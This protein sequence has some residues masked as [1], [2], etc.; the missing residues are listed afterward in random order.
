MWTQNRRT[1]L[2]RSAL[3]LVVM[4]FLVIGF[5]TFSQSG[6]PA[7]PPGTP[8]PI[9]RP[10]LELPQPTA[11]PPTAIPTDIPTEAPTEQPPATALPQP[12]QDNS[13]APG[14][15]VAT[16]TVEPTQ[17][18][19]PKPDT[20]ERPLDLETFC[21]MNITN[22]NDTNPYTFRFTAD[23]SIDIASY[24]WD[25]GDGTTGTGASPA[26]KTYSTV[27]TFNITLVC[28]ISS[29]GSLTLN[30]VINVAAAVF[31][32]FYF[33]D[34]DEYTGVPPFNVPATNTSSGVNLTYA[35]RVSGS[36]NPLDAGLYNYTTANISPT[37]TGADFVAAGFPASGPA[38][39]WYHLTVTDPASGLSATASR[40]VSFTPEAPLYTFDLAPSEVEEGETVTFTAVDLGGGPV[41]TDPST[42]FVW[43]FPGGSP[44]SATGPGPHVITY[45]SEG[46]YSATLN[47]MGPGGG[48]SVSKS[49][50]VFGENTPVDAG[51]VFVSSSGSIG[52][53]E[54][55]FEN[56]STG[57]FVRST[58]N[59]I[60]APLNPP[61]PFENN[62][63]IVCVTY[64]NPGQITV[65]LEVV[66]QEYVDNNG[67]IGQS[68][69]TT[70]VIEL[71]IAPIA[72]FTF[73][74]S[75]VV[76]QG[77]N[78]NFTDTSHLTGGGPVSS[79]AW[80][81]DGV[82]F[83]SQSTAQ[84]PSG[85]PFMTVGD[86]IVRLTVTGPGGSSY[87]EKIVTV[88]RLE[89]GCTI[90]GNPNNGVV[91]PSNGPQT[92]TANV[93]NALG[94]SLTYAW[95]LIRG[96]DGTVLLTGSGNTLTVP[97]DDFDDNYGQYQLS[98]IVSTADGSICNTTRTF[99]REWRE[100]DCRFAG[101]V[102][103]P[104]PLYPTGGTILFTADVRN[105]GNRTPSQYR[106]YV[107]GVLVQSGP[108]NAFTY[109]IPNDST[110]AATLAQ[111]VRYEVDV[112]NTNG[113]Q[114]AYV[115]ATSTCQE[116]RDFD[117]VPWPDLV[118]TANSISGDFTPIPLNDNDG[119]P[120]T[121]T[122]TVNVTGAAGRPVTYTW[123]VVGGTIT[124]GQGSATV[125][126]QWDA[127]VAVEN[128][129]VQNGEI[130][131]TATVTN[132]DGISNANDTCTA[133]RTVGGG[134]GVEIWY[135]SLD[136][137]TPTGDQ[138]VVIGEMSN[139]FTDIVHLYGRPTIS[140]TWI[141]E[142]ESSF[143]AGDWAVVSDSDTTNPFDIYQFMTPNGSYRLSYVFEVGAANGF[144]G[145]SCTSPYLAIRNYDVGFNF[146]C[147]SPAPL[148]IGNGTPN[149]PVVYTYNTVVD[150]TTGL[151]LSYQWSI[152][153]RHGL[154]TLLYGY[155]STV[156]G[157]VY[158]TDTGTAVGTGLTLEQLGPIGPGTYTLRLHVTD[159]SGTATNECDLQRTLIV[160][161]VDANYTYTISGPGT[162][163]NTAL[164][165]NRNIC[166]TNTSTHA[167][168]APAAPSP[169]AVQYTWTIGGPAANN[170]LG[171]GSFNTEGMPCFS[172]NA[173]GS[174]AITV[175]IR[176]AEGNLTD[177][178]SL[179]FNVYG[180]Q[181]ISINRIGSDTSS[182]QSFTSTGVNITGPYNWVFDRLT[183][184]SNPAF[185]TRNNVQNPSNVTGFT[186][187]TYRATVTGTGPLGNTSA[188][189]EFEILALNGLT[190]RFSPSQWAGIA[191]MTV[192]YTDRSISGSPITLWEWDLDGNGSYET[193]GQGPHCYTY[194]DPGMV[195]QVGLR[196]NNGSFTRTATN[197]IR[198]YTPLEASQNFSIVPQG[199]MA[200]C[201]YPD[202]V[203]STLV[204]W[205]FGDGN[206]TGPDDPA[207]HTYSSSGTYLVEMCFASQ[208]TTPPTPGCIYRPVSVTGNTPTP[209]ALT[210]S[211][212]CTTA[213]TAT[214]NLTNTGGAMTTPDQVR[215]LTESG[216]VV[217]LSPLQLAA[218]ESASFSIS[219]YYGVLTLETTDL[220]FTATTLCV[221]YTFTSACAANSL[222]VFTIT[223]NPASAPTATQSYTI[224]DSTGNVIASGNWSIGVGVSSTQVAV[225][226]GN[227]PYETYTIT[228]NGAFGN[229]TDTRGPCAP[230]PELQVT[231]VCRT[232][233]VSGEAEVVFT[234]TNTG[235]AMIVPQSYTIT[236]GTTP[237]GSIQLGAGATTEIVVAPAD[238]P[239]AT[240]TFTSNGFADDVTV[241]HNCG[242]PE[243]SVTGACRTNSTTFEA[244]VVFTITNT[245]SAMLEPQSYSI[246]GGTTPVN[247]TIQL[248]AGGSTEA[249]VNVND[250]P[251]A[252]YTFTSNGFADNVTVNH[253]CSAP[254][255]SAV[256]IC[257]T[258]AVSGEAEVGYTVT[259]NGA[260]MLEPQAYTVVNS[261]SSTVA[262][263]NLFLAN[264]ESVEI[265]IPAA[266]DPYDDYT[267]ITN[268]FAGTISQPHN[269]ARPV[270]TAVGVCSVPRTFNVTN[271]G[272][273]MLEAQAYQVVR[274][275]V[276][277]V[278]GTLDLGAGASTTV[279]LP[280][281]SDPYGVYRFVTAGFATD[282]TVDHDC[283]YP[284]FSSVNVCSYALV[285][286]VTNTGGTPLQSEPW[287]VTDSDGIVVAS[288][289]HDWA[290][291]P[292]LEITLTGLDPYRVYTF[293]TT[294][295]TDDYDADNFVR[296]ESP[297]L[298]VQYT[299]AATPSFTITNNGGDMLTP[300]QLVVSAGGMVLI[301]EPIQLAAGTVQGY[302]LDGANP[303]ET[304]SLST[305]G[306]FAEEIDIPMSCG[307]PDLTV[308]AV[309]GRP[310]GFTVT[311]NGSG[312]VT[313]H[314]YRILS[315]S[316]QSVLLSG[317][318]SL[319]AGE[320]TAIVLP[321]SIDA[322]NGVIFVTDDF[323]VTTETMLTCSSE[324]RTRGEFTGL[325]A[326][327]ATGISAPGCSRG[328][329]VF[330]VY[331]TDEVGGW[332]IFR[333]DSS[334]ETTR[335]SQRTNLSLGLAE[336]IR[337]M[338]PSLS[339]D[340]QW[341]VFSSDRDGNWEIYVAPTSGGSP[342][343]VERV[344]YNTVAIDSDPVWGPGNYIIY[345]T[346]RHGNW[347]LYAV[348]MNTG[349][350]FRLTDSE[351]NDINPYWSEDGSTVVFQSDR[352]DASG[353]RK[354]QVYEL[355]LDT[356]ATTKLSDGST[357]DVDP[358]YSHNGSKVAFRSYGALG[359][360]SRLSLMN[361]DGSGRVAFSDPAGDATNASWS[362]N[363]TYIAYQSDVD[364]DLDIYVY[365]VATGETRHLTDNTVA[366][367][368]PTW[369]CDETRV[370]WT[371]DVMGDANIFE[372][373]A[374]PISDGPI[375]VDPDADQLTFETS[376][377][378]Y[379]LS[380][381]AEENA[382]REGK[383]VRG[384]FGTQTVFLE[385]LVSLTPIDLSTTSITRTEWQPI[386]VCPANTLAGG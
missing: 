145:D 171:Q 293:T 385:P 186:P 354:W 355:D 188:S 57:N 341:I 252:T 198:T 207:C 241:N 230:Q 11:V 15:V 324:T 36:S 9:E 353:A 35:W 65:E 77:S 130:S 315:S 73:S 371:S 248:A 314:N 83:P 125:T 231:G 54:A 383:T 342:E 359:E 262:S 174:Y 159:P 220:S 70:L 48:G 374:A 251:Y 112:D 280:N 292:T 221:E 185:A 196:V 99:N 277:V 358:Q 237:A 6:K 21:R 157:T 333:L 233:A 370:L 138:F 50:N 288:G 129:G 169:D 172:F 211:G 34:G 256:G 5:P 212:S 128:G 43:S 331:H 55:C 192:C 304:Y 303:Y 343:S 308:T 39:I 350:E 122:Y 197:T 301:D 67:V 38:I 126:V 229:Y 289:T 298:E 332:E 167:P 170:S 142:Q 327:A 321:D 286:V 205:G 163:T 264:G 132:P 219:G 176:N 12:T 382:S 291:V 41:N 259:N 143:G 322:T 154:E 2:S 213:G 200:F 309:C 68:S 246:T 326:P 59:F 111:N 53:I 164:P 147:E 135:E 30:G 356:L 195:V 56:T 242:Q 348:D 69:T 312:L 23:G 336:D 194:P 373:D 113:G 320:S 232:N 310:A 265:L 92:Y 206:G 365:E 238:N 63:P 148:L 317:T 82:P 222:P 90:T 279:S 105:L 307:T 272:G 75:P 381:P 103:I 16:A 318:F 190:A 218:G 19:A 79:W 245:G 181:S 140:L 305:S 261:A 216:N 297:A 76:V 325:D 120:R 285:I 119:N 178:Y 258:N 202:L 137:N 152:I 74:P 109:T 121:D 347:D 340:N 330:K 62:D 31:A 150:N 366:D 85:I 346:T 13:G 361:A 136:C 98:L 149:S 344:T 368:A 32:S 223:K 61:V 28:N 26:A 329:P 369:L 33:P 40:S 203:N 97:W 89:I 335:T 290:S 296:C 80:T 299:C 225:P 151:N 146:E 45:N 276:D 244:E 115:P 334:D 337:S 386:N 249:I 162:W 278:T 22:N 7:R 60:P 189:L 239:Y 263:G 107:N 349:A 266:A 380:N 78:V 158:S 3:L 260:A 375:L 363:D 153:D 323:G 247:G 339:P 17:T 10:T 127:T 215:I 84:N 27:G 86:H 234:V 51:V 66:D 131:V 306:G 14:E 71:T 199:G 328:C 240:Y 141:L 106:W 345:E 114:F 377:D 116:D 269:C 4:S 243:L 217:L 208:T 58:W 47:Y 110:L 379:P 184:T 378:I 273:T 95:T 183:P 123:S 117:V 179:T 133:A 177:S 155:S 254:T 193:T 94:R 1:W 100:L 300:Q 118:C 191:P 268:G 360:N 168:A 134:N 139:H 311:N 253:A 124:G 316:D 283:P 209:P 362:P 271:N 255:M 313:D 180:L 376:S 302:S 187:G 161:S 182:S 284:Q 384:A 364:G 160:G 236:P 227:N 357:I 144:E 372:A 101:S 270:I 257:R 37:L 72:D 274:E 20:N 25:F 18:Q 295:F 210:G 87:V 235:G 81:V 352:Q 42:A 173:P 104:S 204:G 52:A 287:E 267:F 166:L 250:D 108:S 275:G 29:G 64:A 228:S 91:V 46:T 214:F 93:S 8:G 96:S 175:Q 319:E 294:G 156:D 88:S 44:N 338:A 367:Y 281:G 102:S 226:D 24:A 224:T 49:V 351:G 165:V 282:L 201:F